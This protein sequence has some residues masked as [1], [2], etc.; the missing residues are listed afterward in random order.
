MIKCCRKDEDR[1]DNY[2]LYIHMHMIIN[3]YQP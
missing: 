3:K 2:N 1:Y